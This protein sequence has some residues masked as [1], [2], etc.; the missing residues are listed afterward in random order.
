MSG[1]DHV[2]DEQGPYAHTSAG[3]PYDTTSDA[4]AV[5]RQIYQRMG[6]RARLAIAFRLSDAIRRVAMAG[7]QARHPEYSDEQ[8]FRAWA[9]LNLGDTLTRSV[10]P[11]RDLIDP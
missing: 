2:H 5:Q 11:D 4:H 10:W 7:I 3:V 6:G 8:V 9:R 1:P